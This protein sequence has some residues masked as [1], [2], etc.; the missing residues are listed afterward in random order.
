MDIQFHCTS[1]TQSV[2]VDSSTAG[3]ATECPSCG[4]AVQ[5]PS[6][7]SAPGGITAETPLQMSPPAVPAAPPS[8]ETIYCTKCGQKNLENHFRCV[9]CGAHLHAAPPPL[10]D[11]GSLQSL[12]PTKNVSALVGYYL[13]VFSLI[14][15]IGIPLGIAAVILGIKGRRF[16]RKLPEAKGGAHAMTAIILGSLSAIGYTLLIATPIILSAIALKH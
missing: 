7:A 9:Q 1:C 8:E 12:I 15:F 10:P 13:G 4:A 11:G 3:Q 6:H 16:A 14:P 2:T 5:V